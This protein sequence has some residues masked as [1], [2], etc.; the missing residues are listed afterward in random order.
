[1]QLKGFEIN[2]QLSFSNTVSIF[3]LSEIIGKI[4]PLSYFTLR[5][6]DNLKPITFSD[7]TQHQIETEYL[8]LAQMKVT[9]KLSQ[10]NYDVLNFVSRLD[11]HKNGMLHLHEMFT[12]LAT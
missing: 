5:I 9:N 11:I 3:S 1:M 4:T 2:D 7:L 10:H 6:I 8:R 12:E